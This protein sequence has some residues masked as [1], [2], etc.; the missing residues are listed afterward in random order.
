MQ[1]GKGELTPEQ[2]FTLRI[3]KLTPKQKENLNASM[4]G[5]V[6]TQRLRFPTEY[7]QQG[8]PFGTQASPPV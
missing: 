4:T 3:E 1:E 8:T 5:L 6:G 2:Q 7:I